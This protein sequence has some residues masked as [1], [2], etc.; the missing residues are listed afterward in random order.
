MS[1][2]HRKIVSAPQH[3]QY[4]QIVHTEEIRRIQYH[5]PFHICRS[6]NSHTY[7]QDLFITVIFKYA[8]HDLKEIRKKPVRV[9]GGD[10]NAPLLQNIQFKITEG[11]PAFISGY[12]DT[13]YLRSP[14]RYLQDNGIPPLS[15]RFLLFLFFDYAFTYK[16]AHHIGGCHL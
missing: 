1:D 3:P 11:N 10:I 12:M 7:T 5:S 4:I 13:Q 16:L 14:G 15:D 9:P 6:Q 8:V 2:D